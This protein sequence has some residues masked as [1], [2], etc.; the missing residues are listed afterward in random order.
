MRPD[1]IAAQNALIDIAQGV[2]EDAKALKKASLIDSLKGFGL[3]QVAGL[4]IAATASQELGLAV[5]TIIPPYMLAK[6]MTKTGHMLNH[7]NDKFQRVVQEDYKEELQG[8]EHILSPIQETL[9]KDHSVNW[10]DSLNPLKNAFNTA[11]AA[12]ISLIVSPLIFPTLYMINIEGQK[13][14][15]ASKI[16]RSARDLQEQLGV[17]PN[18]P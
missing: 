5:M 14:T 17:S 12:G 1:E 18:K 2:E 9:N 7:L 16:I 8:Y 3:P 11:L 13:R 6:N 4:A 10:T 15:D